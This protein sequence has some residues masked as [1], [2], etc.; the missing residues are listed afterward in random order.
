MRRRFARGFLQYPTSS[1]IRP[2]CKAC[3]GGVGSN[4]LRKMICATSIGIRSVTRTC[5]RNVGKHV[6]GVRGLEARPASICGRPQAGTSLLRSM[7][8]RAMPPANCRATFSRTGDAARPKARAEVHHR[9]GSSGARRS[10]PRSAGRAGRMALT[11]AN[12]CC[13]S[14]TPLASMKAAC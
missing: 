9:A 4:A 11:Y 1:Y 2:E 13:F 10:L 12:A 7:R 8:C 5:K 14:N 6:P 3:G